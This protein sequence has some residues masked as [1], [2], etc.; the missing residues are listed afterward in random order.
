[1]PELPNKT[2]LK[3]SEVRAFLDVTAKTFRKMTWDSK[4]DKA[5]DKSARLFHAIHLPGYAWPVFKRTQ[6]LS[7]LAKAEQ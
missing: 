4:R 6:V 5:R 2:Y 7:A 3:G 1:M